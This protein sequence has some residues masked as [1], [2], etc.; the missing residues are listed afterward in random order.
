MP[1]APRERDADVPLGDSELSGAW[2]IV[3]AIMNLRDR[4]VDV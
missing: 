3:L 2:R 1:R 4:S